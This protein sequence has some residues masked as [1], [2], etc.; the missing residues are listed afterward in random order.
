ML[1]A[2]DLPALAV[3]LRPLQ[4]VTMVCS[5]PT[6]PGRRASWQ[7]ERHRAVCAALLAGDA[8]RLRQALREHFA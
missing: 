4:Q 2:T 7:L 8:E 6:Q 3:M 1:R 5:R